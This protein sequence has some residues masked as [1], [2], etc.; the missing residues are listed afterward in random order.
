[1]TERYPSRVFAFGTALH[2]ALE[3]KTFPT[4]PGLDDP[5]SVQFSHENPN[6]P[7]VICVALNA[8][9]TTSEWRR[10]SPAGRDETITFDVVAYVNVP[11]ETSAE[12]WAYLEELAEV[13]ESVVYDFDANQ[14]IPLG[15]DGETLAGLTTGARP[16]VTP[17]KE[18]WIG[19]VAVPFRFLAC[20]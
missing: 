3:T 11:G 20:I 7:V 16:F 1:M 19:A 12:V 10:L 5:P 2:A 13:I 8:D 4:H 15:V 6:D 17:T 14:V 9:E 18:G